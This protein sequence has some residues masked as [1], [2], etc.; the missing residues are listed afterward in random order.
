[1]NG[2]YTSTL[3][4]Q[5]T[6]NSLETRQSLMSWVLS[7]HTDSILDSVNDSRY[8]GLRGIKVVKFLWK[9]YVKS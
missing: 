3:F 6:R 5:E 4:P 8:S 9:L 1:M 7:K 2:P